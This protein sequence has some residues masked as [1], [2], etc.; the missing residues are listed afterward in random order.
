MN[1]AAERVF[2]VAM[3]ATFACAAAVIAF[4]AGRD[5]ERGRV[6]RDLWENPPGM[7]SC[8]VYP[9]GGKRCIPAANPMHVDRAECI[10]ACKT[11]ARMERVGR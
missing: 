1:R 10:T 9:D 3:T 11:R 4:D 6:V 2:A 7:T 8:V 5:Y